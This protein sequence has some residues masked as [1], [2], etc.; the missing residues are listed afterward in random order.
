M[1]DIIHLVVY[2]LAVSVSVERAVDILKRAIVQRYKVDTV[3]GVLYQILSTCFGAIIAIADNP[4]F[5]FITDKRW[6]MV[7]IIALAVSG[8]S[9]AWNTVLSILKELSL[10]KTT[11]TS[12]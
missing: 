8:G 7:V 2:L 11:E 1:D 4:N 6:L 10:P 9:S 12:K 5:Y 3:N